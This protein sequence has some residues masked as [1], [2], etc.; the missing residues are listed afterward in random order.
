LSPVLNTEQFCGTG[1]QFALQKCRN[2]KPVSPRDGF[3]MNK[4]WQQKW[5]SCVNVI[6][7][8]FSPQMKLTSQQSLPG[9][10]MKKEI[11]IPTSIPKIGEGRW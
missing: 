5:P 2:D 7:S 4:R 8:G 6:L 1:I 11:H 9:L 10:K 3:G